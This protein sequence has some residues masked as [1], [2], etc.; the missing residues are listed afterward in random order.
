MLRWGSWHDAVERFCHHG[1]S[2]SD[3]LTQ[4]PAYRL[5]QAVCGYDYC[6]LRDLLEIKI[7]PGYLGFH[8]E[9]LRAIPPSVSTVRDASFDMSAK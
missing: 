1:S 8:Y 5:V 6:S 4:P 2:K 3:C 9:L 7:L